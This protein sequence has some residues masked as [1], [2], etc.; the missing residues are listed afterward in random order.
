MHSTLKPKQTDDPH[1]FVVVVPEAARVAPDP[2]RVVPDPVALA[3]ADEELSSL[4]HDAARR[5]SQAQARAASGVPAVARDARLR[6]GAV[7]NVHRCRRYRL[8]ALRRCRPTDGRGLDAAARLDVVVAVGT[9]GSISATG[10]T[11]RSG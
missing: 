2:A 8:A 7:G 6:R 9:T 3:P 4:L 1:D 5:L 10:A 11:G